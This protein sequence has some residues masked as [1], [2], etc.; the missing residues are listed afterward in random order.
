M[1]MCQILSTWIAG[2]QVEDYID[3]GQQ[4]GYYHPDEAFQAA[5][6]QMAAAAAAGT[7]GQYGAHGVHH[8]A[9]VQYSVLSL[10]CNVGSCAVVSREQSQPL[11]HEHMFDTPCEWFKNSHW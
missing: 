3:D 11:Y 9:Q 1:E 5:A 4:G 2:V 6:Q 10:S 8:S 7:N